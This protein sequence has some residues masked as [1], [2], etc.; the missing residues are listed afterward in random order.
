M[1]EQKLLV[2]VHTNPILAKAYHFSSPDSKA[3][4]SSGLASRRQASLKNLSWR[5]VLRTC[6]AW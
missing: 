6:P 1:Q 3:L 4:Y 5:R 2:S